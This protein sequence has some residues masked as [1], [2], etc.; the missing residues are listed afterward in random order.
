MNSTFDEALQACD[1]PQASIFFSVNTVNLGNRLYHSNGEEI[2]GNSSSHLMQ[3][4]GE[5]EDGH[6]RATYVCYVGDVIS[7]LYDLSRGSLIE[8]GTEEYP[9]V[10]NVTVLLHNTVRTVPLH[11][12]CFFTI[13]YQV[14]VSFASP[15]VAA[16]LWTRLQ[17]EKLSVNANYSS[18]SGAAVKY[19]SRHKFVVPLRHLLVL[20]PY[21]TSFQAPVA[22]E[23]EDQFIVVSLE[24][25]EKDDI[26]CE[27]DVVDD[28][29]GVSVESTPA[30]SMSSPLPSSIAVPST[31]K[32]IIP[33]L[34]KKDV[35]EEAVP[36]AP[37]KLPSR[38][39]SRATGDGWQ[40]AS[41]KGRKGKKKAYS[42]ETN[43]ET[44]PAVR[45]AFDLLQADVDEADDSVM[46]CAEGIAA[47]RHTM[48]S[49]TAVW[50]DRVEVTWP[51]PRCTF[52]NNTIV[53]V[54]TQSMYAAD[55]QGVQE[56][57]VRICE[58]CEYA[59]LC[60]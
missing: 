56:S 5:G 57:S 46:P 18:Q 49:N 32:Y 3:L 16:E 23:Q 9:L 14:Q 52:I 33:H 34:R 22:V 54:N 17:Q 4:E 58:M 2:Q 8:K 26:L 60:D 44:K 38:S 35:T 30:P 20:H 25:E 21:V 27:D 43:A 19:Q 29:V 13:P 28:W 15:E 48:S 37:P 59:S 55:E 40:E 11:S 31:G 24:E 36:P 1:N 47:P 7:R 51:C 39:P 42:E 41:S 10:T 50:D 12:D 53:N 45:S 6:P